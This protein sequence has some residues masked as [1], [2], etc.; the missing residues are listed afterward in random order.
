[1]NIIGLIGGMSWE[2]TQT[3]YR[4]I[5]EE[6][7]A[8]LG[9]LHS[10]DILLRSVDFAPIA[11]L[12]K[13]DNWDEAGRVLADVARGL[14]GA[15]AACV[16][17]C[18]NTMHIVADTVADAIR[19]P[20]IH[21]VDA[22]GDALVRDGIRRPLLLGTR[23]TMERDF[24]RGRLRERY[25]IEALVPEA[26]DRTFVHDVIF[27]ELCLGVINDASRRRYLDII[28][29]GRQ[30]GADAVILGCTEVGLLIRATDVDLPLFDTTLLHADAAV[31]FAL[32]S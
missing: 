30:S 10:A 26:D 20:L 29:R 17:I 28:G 31:D 23:F 11:E 25:G 7:R 32:R 4:R 19:V 27:G 14:E 1:M 3:Y 13:T 2:S 9:G 12:Q 21:I 8:R 15:G 5:N 22:T 16:L 6:V 18:T 24:Y